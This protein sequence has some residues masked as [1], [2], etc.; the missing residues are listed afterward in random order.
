M[1]FTNADVAAAIVA[2]WQFEEEI[3][4]PI[5]YQYNPDAAP[6]EFRLRSIM[7]YLAI[8]A[9]YLIDDDSNSFEEKY[10]PYHEYM[11]ELA[12]TREGLIEAAKH[13]NAAI[14]KFSS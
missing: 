1:G 4:V 3:T 6:D 9:A 7:L 13:G 2:D 11:L 14:E 5:S 8:D 10:D 12:L